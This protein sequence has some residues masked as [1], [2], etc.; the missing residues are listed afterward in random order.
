MY[1]VTHH[2]QDM[3]IDGVRVLRR[4]RIVGTLWPDSM[5]NRESIHTAMVTNTAVPLND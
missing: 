3:L 2:S 1:R 5:Q 4:T